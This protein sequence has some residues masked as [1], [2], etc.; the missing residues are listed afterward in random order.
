MV[1]VGTGIGALNTAFRSL[2]LNVDPA[3]VLPGGGSDRQQV[4]R[5]AAAHAL[6]F[7]GD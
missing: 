1:I 3:Y 4:A 6:T 5:P 2:V 7:S